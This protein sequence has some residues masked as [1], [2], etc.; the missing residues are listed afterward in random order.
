[1][2]TRLGDIWI[3]DLHSLTWSNPELYGIPPLSRSLHTANIINN[4]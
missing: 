1:M 3:L 4:R 2:G